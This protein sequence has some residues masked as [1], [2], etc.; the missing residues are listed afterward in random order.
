MDMECDF[1][2]NLKKRKRQKHRSKSALI[3]SHSKKKKISY[4]QQVCIK[5]VPD[6]VQ[7]NISKCSSN[8]QLSLPATDT[9][10][11]LLASTVENRS[12]SK[13]SSEDETL[14]VVSEVLADSEPS[15]FIQ[16]CINKCKNVFLED[17]IKNFDKEGLLLHFMAFMEMISSGQLSVVNMA[18]LLAM[19]MAL[20]FTLTSTMQM[21]YRRDTSLFWETVLAV[22]GPRTLWLFLSDKHF[23][24]VNSGE[25][26]KSKYVPN[27]EHFNFAV[28]DEKTFLKSKMGLPK[29]IPCG[30]IEE[31]VQLLDKEK[32]FVLSLDGKQ[33]IP[34]LL[35]ENEGDVNLCGYEGPPTLKENLNHLERHKDIILDIVGKASID[36]NSLDIFSEDLKLVVHIITKQIRDLRQAKVRQEQLQSRFQKKISAN[37]DIGSR[38]DVAF[39]GIDCFI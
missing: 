12:S 10:T 26:A 7:H 34:G 2:H 15:Q 20:I 3:Q 21:R 23:S 1:S 8:F 28:P 9:E 22:G 27:K 16:E 4:G 19:E 11:K 14:D 17:V 31:S 5:K 35:N 33:L 37:P 36:D 18:V 32:E 38:Y 29:V 30:I 39:S 13:S 25:S 24:Q 6:E